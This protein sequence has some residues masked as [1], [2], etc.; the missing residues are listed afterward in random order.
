MHCGPVKKGVGTIMAGKKKDEKEK[1]LDKMTVKELR[2]IAK[3]IPDIVGVHGMNKGD[4]LV[5]IKAHRGITDEPKKKASSSVRDIKAK[6]RTLKV[7]RAAAKAEN[8]QKMFDIY[9]RRISRLKK[10]TRQAA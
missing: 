9:R 5:A 4:L 3:Q 6:I 8:N 1:P 2:E 7:K 10:K